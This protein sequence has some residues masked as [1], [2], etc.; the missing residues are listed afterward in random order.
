MNFMKGVFYF[1]KAGWRHA[2]RGERENLLILPTKVPGSHA[3]L[4]RTLYSLGG[5]TRIAL[6]PGY[7][8]IFNKGLLRTNTR[9][10]EV[11]MSFNS[12]TKVPWLMPPALGLPAQIEEVPQA[13]TDYVMVRPK[14][15]ARGE[16][17]F[18]FRKNETEKILELV[19]PREKENWGAFEYVEPHLVMGRKWDFRVHVLVVG[20][21]PLRLYIGNPDLGGVRFALRNFTM[22]SRDGAGVHAPGSYE[23]KKAITGSGLPYERKNETYRLALGAM[24]RK[25]FFSYDAH[26]FIYD[27]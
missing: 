24:A 20:C 8:G 10:F 2:A 27:T 7:N 25:Y 13:R 15:S 23:A 12:S 17:T 18:V 5:E 14:E 3:G 9:A 26:R 19:T 6:C 1:L 21:D 22:E 11:S 16:D 4:N